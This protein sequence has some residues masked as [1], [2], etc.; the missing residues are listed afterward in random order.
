LW[1]ELLVEAG[2]TC[3][4]PSASKLDILGAIRLAAR[5]KPT[6]VPAPGQEA[7]V[8]SGQAELTNRETQ[9]FELLSKGR[10]NLEIASALHISIETVTTHV[11][12][13]FRKLG[14]HKR[15]QLSGMRVPHRRK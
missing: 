7:R 8:V 6:Y 3:V 5:G 9:V 14:V 11:A 12:K 15:Q 10:T 4:D 13:I 2:A 1:G